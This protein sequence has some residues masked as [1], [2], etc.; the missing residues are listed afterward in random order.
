MQACFGWW[1]YSRTQLWAHWH[2]KLRW[3][4][5]SCLRGGG[6]MGKWTNTGTNAHRWCTGVCNIVS[7]SSCLNTDGICLQEDADYNLCADRWKNM[8]DDAVKSVGNLQWDRYFPRPL[9]SWVCIGHSWHGPERGAVCHYLYILC[10]F[11]LTLSFQS[12]ISPCRCG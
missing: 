1:G 11:L 12:K 2:K 9:S 8:K 5:L 10:S 4:L 3:W 7:I 6:Q